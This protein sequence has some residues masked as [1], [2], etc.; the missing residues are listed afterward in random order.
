MLP[1]RNYRPSVG[2]PSKV[3]SLQENCGSKP[4]EHDSHCKQPTANGA[5]NKHHLLTSKYRLAPSFLA[6]QGN[7]FSVGQGCTSESLQTPLLCS[8][9]ESGH[10]VEPAIS[11]ATDLDAR[12]LLQASNAPIFG[13]KFEIDSVSKERQALRSRYILLA[14]WNSSRS[15]TFALRNSSQTSLGSA[16]LAEMDFLLGRAAWCSCGKTCGRVDQ[17]KGG[18]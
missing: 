10:A 18:G 15:K 3:R 4:A 11:A 17:G 7:T 13:G 1:Q 9:G 8:C 16:S 2:P 5:Q 12:R 14:Q 6:L